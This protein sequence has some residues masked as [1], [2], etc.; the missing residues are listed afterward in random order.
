MRRKGR[1]QGV[2]LGTVVMLVLVIAVTGGMLRILPRLMGDT[3]IVIDTSIGVQKTFDLSDVFPALALSDIPIGPQEEPTAPIQVVMEG[4]VPQETP[5][6]T[7]QPIATAT[8]PPTPTPTIM[9]TI[10]AV[11]ESRMITLTLGGSINMDDAVRKSGYYSDSKKY[12]YAETFSL[13][14][15]EMQSDLVVLSLENL[16]VPSAKVSAL[17][18]PEAV[19]GDLYDYGVDVVAL[20]FPQAYEQGLDGLK[21][22]IAAAREQQLGVIGAYVSE[23]D[24][25]Q[26][27]MRTINGVQ[28]ALLHYTQELSTKSKAAIKKDG[29]AFAV[30]LAQEA[31]FQADIAQAREQGADVVVVSMNWGSSGKGTPTKQQTTLAQQIADAGADIIYGTGTRVVQTVSWLTGKRSDGSE[32]Q[33]LCAY[34][35]GSLLNESRKDGNVAGILLQLTLSLDEE[36]GNVC[37]DRTAYTP[38]YIWRFTQDGQSQYRIVASDR[39]P[40]VGMSDD[41][42]RFKDNAYANIRNKMDA[43]PLTLR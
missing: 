9:P 37:F 4:F 23:K 20:G 28:I 21:D 33:T 10:S 27:M 32:H 29:N 41:Q 43:T 38:T 12:D 31:R 22:T 3:H 42:A 26:P 35:L 19:M 15:D 7:Q 30:P 39:E 24:A 11:E 25:Q 8:L 36:T 17:I 6:A 40:P 16:I 2:S 34:S 1:H 18:A 5:A 14:S 13:L